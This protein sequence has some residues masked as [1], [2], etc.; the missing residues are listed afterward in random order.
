MIIGLRNI[1]PSFTTSSEKP[2]TNSSNKRINL[3]N[4]NIVEAPPK[5][6]N[7]VKSTNMSSTDGLSDLLKLLDRKED[8]VITPADTRMATEIQREK[9]ELLFK[10]LSKLP[11]NS[12]EFIAEPN[13]QLRVVFRGSEQQRQDTL[14][15]IKLQL[16]NIEDKLLENSYKLPEKADS[17]GNQVALH[18][19]TNTTTHHERIDVVSM[20][21]LKSPTTENT[22]PSKKAKEQQKAKSNFLSRFIKDIKSDTKERDDMLREASRHMSDS[23]HQIGQAKRNTNTLKNHHQKLRNAANNIPKG[24]S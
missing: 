6:I 12:I 14:D 21:E 17:V 22:Q 11:K 5:K 19:H 16:N 13:G 24:K 7:N 10:M 1:L 15:M 3:K 9:K 4:A 20:A 18:T 2:K 8:G 23:A